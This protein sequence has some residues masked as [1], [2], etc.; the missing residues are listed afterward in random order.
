MAESNPTPARPRRAKPIKGVYKRQTA[1]GPT[2]IAMVRLRGFKSVAKSFAN[3]DAAEA[4]LFATRS[5]LRKQRATG[6]VRHDVSRMTVGD[7]IRDY[8]KDPA[9]T[10]LR[11]FDN[12]E[13]LLCRWWLPKYG[14]KRVLDTS[15]L[16]LREARE[17]LGSD[18]KNPR[19]SATVNRH[20]S[21]L[22]SVWN[23]GRAAGL[24]PQERVWPTKLMLPEP[25]GRVRYLSDEE[26]ANVLKAAAAQDSVMRAMIIVSL[27]TGVRQGE[28][29]QLTWADIDLDKAQIR[30]LL[31]KNN[32][33]RSVALTPT[34]VEALRA[35]K[36][37]K[38]VSAAHPFLD[39]DG[40]P[41]TKASLRYPW[42]LI[43]NAA[44]LKNFK[45]HDLRHSCASYLA[46][47]GSNLLEIGSVLGHRSPSMTMRY[48]HL[49]AGK[50]VTGHA[51]LDEKL[52]G[53]P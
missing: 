18:P 1:A 26:L 35:L 51:A 42:N 31:T 41:Y 20:L 24:I 16:V 17:K 3:R 8:L 14:S 19:Q 44:G 37:A 33:S 13:E 15:V 53:K 7:L 10:A 52:R 39:P 46:Q 30:V 6:E 49:V 23:W 45:W 21:A 38:I 50:P 2:F 12:K 4:W 28:L 29:L 27:A 34:A 32:E 5:E 25:K 40:E 11:S 48:A 9:T 43:R 22:R 47:N 36:K